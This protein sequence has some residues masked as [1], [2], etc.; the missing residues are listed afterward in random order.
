MEMTGQGS[1]Q[2]PSDVQFPALLPYK[3]R[4]HR[5]SCLEISVW[6]QTLCRIE[7]AKQRKQQNEKQSKHTDPCESAINHPLSDDE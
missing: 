2:T 5:F 3:A 6:A 4:G 1:I 7:A